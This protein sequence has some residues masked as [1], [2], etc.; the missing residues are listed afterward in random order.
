MENVSLKETKRSGCNDD[1]TRASSAFH[2]QHPHHHHLHLRHL[3]QVNFTEFDPLKIS[4]KFSWSARIYRIT[5]LGPKTS[6]IH[7]TSLPDQ[8]ISHSMKSW[9]ILSSLSS[10]SSFPPT[11]L[12]FIIRMFCV[13]YL[14][15]QAYKRNTN[16]RYAASAW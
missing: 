12:I 13:Q 1:K 8:K 6:R 2:R 16:M 11:L 3:S 10:S 4:K 5:Q 9:Y 14:G 7:F 15:L